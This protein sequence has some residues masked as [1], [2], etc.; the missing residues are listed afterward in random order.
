LEIKG[1]EEEERREDDEEDEDD[2]EDMSEKINCSLKD[3]C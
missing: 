3:E 2:D 1:E